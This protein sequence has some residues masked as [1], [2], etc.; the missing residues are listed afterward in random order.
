MLHTW[1][2]YLHG[3]AEKLLVSPGP[4]TEDSFNQSQVLPLY[5]WRR[6][7]ICGVL[8]SFTSYPHLWV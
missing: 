8:G 4:S 1:L 7:G 6:M 3:P 5:S 2:L